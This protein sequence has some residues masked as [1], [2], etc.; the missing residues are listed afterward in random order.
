MA[1]SMDKLAKELKKQ[2]TASDE[3]KP[4]PYDTQAEVTR[5]EGNIAWVHIPGGVDETPVRLTINA[6]KGDNVNLHVANGTAWITG[7]STNPPTDDSTANYAV[8]ISNEVKKDVIVLNTVVAENIE[9]TNARFTN[10]EVDT[11]KIHDL[12]ADKLHATVGYIDDLTADSITANDISAA[13]GYIK[14]LEADNI[15]T[16]DISASSGYIKDLE[17]DNITAQDIS[18]SSGYI[19]DLT[20]G[21]VTAQNVIA[22]HAT[23]GNLDTTYAKINAANIDTATIRNAWVDKIMVQTGLLAYSSQIYTLDAIEV[24]AANITAGTLDVNRLIVTVDEG[25]SAQKYLVKIDPSTGTPSYEKLD[26]N[27]VEPRTITANKIVAN[28]ITTDEITVNNL[29]GTSGWINLHDGK[30]FYGNGADFATSANAI[31]WNGSKLQIKADEFLLSTGKTIQDSIES[32]ENWFYSVPPT[33]S[34][35]PANSWTTTNLK[36]QHLRDIYFDTTSGKSYRWAKEGSTYKWVEIEDVE[37]AAL[38]KD[39]HDNYPPRSE[40]TVAPNQ[41]QSTVSAAQTAATNAANSAT[42]TK[43]QSYYTKTQTD[44]AITQRAGEISLEVAQTE[45]AN[46]EVG[47]RNLVP[48][49]HMFSGQGRVVPSTNQ[50]YIHTASNERGFPLCHT[51]DILA[52]LVPPTIG[53]GEEIVVSFDFKMDSGGDASHDITFYAYQSNG[54]SIAPGKHELTADEK[55]TTWTRITRVTNA[56]N[57]G[58]VNTSR[59]IG[60]IYFYDQTGNN[61]FSVRN[62][63]IERGNKAT[64]WTPAPEDVEAYTD[65][66]VSAAKAEIKVTTDGISSEVSKV[67]SAKYVTSSGSG[68]TLANIK[69]YAAEGHIDNWNV[70]STENVRA[71]DVVYVYGKDTTRNCYVYIK[72]TV[73]SVESST[74]FSG[75]SHGYE[76]ILP[77]ETIKSTINQSADSVKIHANHVEI[78][79]TATFNAIKS[80]VENTAQT[81]VDNVEIGGRDMLSDTRDFDTKNTTGIYL[82]SIGNSPLTTDKYKGLLIRNYPSKTISSGVSDIFQYFF[83]TTNTSLLEHGASYCLSFWAKGSGKFRTYFYS[84]ASGYCYIAKYVASDGDAMNPASGDGAKIWTLTNEWKR[85]WIVYTF[86]TTGHLD[87]RRVLFRHDYNASATFAGE[88]CGIKLEAGNKPTEWTPA[89]EDIDAGIATAQATANSANAEEQR[90]YYRTDS[91]GSLAKPTIWIT[92]NYQTYNDG[93]S[94]GNSGWARV[95]T[96]IANSINPTKKYLYLYSAVQRKTV[97]G[98]ITCSDVLLDGTTTVIDGG[99]IVTGTVAANRIDAASGTFNTANIP[100][101]DAGKITT[102]TINIGRIPEDAKNSNVTVGG[103]NYIIKSAGLNITGLGS[104]AGSHNEYRALDVGSS[105]MDIP[106]GTQVA[107]SFDLYMTV[108][109]ANPTLLVYNT[110]RKCPKAFA[111][112]AGVDQGGVTLSFTA[113]AGSIINK[114][115]SLIGYINDRPNPTITNNFIEFYSNYGTSNWFS[116]S[117]IKLEVGN[118]ATDWTPAPEDEPHR[119][120]LTGTDE[121]TVNSRTVSSTDSASY[122]EG[123]SF[124]VPRI[125]GETEYV[126]SFEA[127]ASVDTTVRC[128]WYNPSTTTNAKSSTGHTSTSADGNC[129]VSLTTSW[130]RYWVRWTQSDNVSTSKHLI[131]GRIFRPSSGSVTVDIRAIKMEAGTYATPWTPA[132]EDLAATA[133]NYITHIDNNGIRVHPSS[134]ENNSVVINATGMEVFKGGTGSAN[135]VAFYGDTARIGTPDKWRTE[136][137]PSGLTVYGNYASNQGVELGHIGYANA[138]SG[139]GSDHY[140]YFTFG[141]RPSSGTIGGISF[142]ANGQNTASGYKSFACGQATHAE[143]SMSFASGD[144]TTA[145]GDMSFACGSGTVAGSRC[146][147]AIGEYNNNSSSN[148]FEIGKGSSSSRKNIFAVD[149]SGNVN[150]PS[151][152]NYKINGVSISSTSRTTFTPTSGASYS[153]Y[154]GCYY[155]KYGNVV[156]VHV[157]VSG[158]TANTATNIATLPAGYRPYSTVFAHGTGG[159]WNNLG[160]LEVTSAGVVTVRSAGTYCGA[161]VTFIV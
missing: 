146:Q 122:K 153:N 56:Y 132:P 50:S 115:V 66:Q 104:T 29:V 112:A 101:L 83:P 130:N 108:N 6:K 95:V 144:G 53:E 127:K 114:R 123:I 32:V 12:T 42:D 4:K 8:N 92:N 23:V 69:T 78:D 67:S 27:I 156:H 133:T 103:R 2:I 41:I 89:P 7:N 9:A 158:L 118:K 121:T 73:R 61:Y 85:Y 80:N 84:A 82:T 147:V 157:G 129:Y 21:N 145:R 70:T 65:T 117:N 98:T 31:S 139:S 131:V 93:R 25:S 91:A 48:V 96:P 47:G 126:A 79:G 154:G 111:A 155:E 160:Y 54:I 15:T 24:N 3:R 26:G 99:N 19:K 77:V 110:N 113:A 37:L 107:M 75:V 136:I 76:D 38:A 94:I 30:F 100:N 159:S 44:S 58:D 74:R 46:I 10:V 81:A 64:D 5:V 18:A 62:V 11:A 135:S 88:F 72:T 87:T 60:C 33:T 1:S 124:T 17:A 151:G 49:T 120:L 45:I 161:D 14:D 36:E 141:S 97:D 142:V 137:S 39:L 106:H 148:M 43:L 105:Y 40:F 35:A 13:S 57:F 119:N 63:K 109:T 34:N 116:I 59:T 16:Q 102:G 68:W 52:D 28:S 152:T 90:I 143:G 138:N 128:Y 55:Q 51:S 125:E 71:G 140:P 134:T 22:D 20:A 150:I 149:T 86:A